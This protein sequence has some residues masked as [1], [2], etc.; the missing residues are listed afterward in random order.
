MI[1]PSPTVN[2]PKWGAGYTRILAGHVSIRLDPQTVPVA[3]R[4]P[5]HRLVPPIQTDGGDGGCGVG[6]SGFHNDGG[7]HR[8]GTAGLTTTAMRTSRR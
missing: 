1:R 4:S 7:A 8:G 3:H 2:N 6:D 5:Q